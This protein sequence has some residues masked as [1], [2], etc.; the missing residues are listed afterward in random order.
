MPNLPQFSLNPRILPAILAAALVSAAGSAAANTSFP[1]PADMARGITMTPAQ[2]AALPHA[3]WV[4]A[5][6]RAF[7]IRYYIST[8]GGSGTRPVVFLQGDKPWRFDRNTRAFILPPDV[9]P[10]DPTNLT[11]FADRFSRAAGTTAIIV[12]GFGLI[13]TY[14]MVPIT[15]SLA[16]AMPG[17]STRANAARVERSS[18][19]A[20]IFQDSRS[21]SDPLGR[22]GSSSIVAGQGVRPRSCRLRCGRGRRRNPREAGSADA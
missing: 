3:V 6:G 19:I 21:G 16:V 9:R 7:C 12:I 18:I 11:R 8:V 14:V 13:W 15:G 1:Q 2:C 17:A 4:R 22:I 5:M 20:P 10:F